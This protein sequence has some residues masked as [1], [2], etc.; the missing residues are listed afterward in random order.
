MAVVADA[1]RSTL[2]LDGA[3]CPCCRKPLAGTPVAICR[4]CIA[5]YHGACASYL[6]ACATYGCS[7]T[8][9]TYLGV[10]DG[11]VSVPKGDMEWE[12]P[13]ADPEP[14]PLEPRGVRSFSVRGENRTATH[15]SSSGIPSWI[16][17]AVFLVAINL[18]RFG[19][20]TNQAAPP[21]PTF[22][23]PVVFPG[24]SPAPL[25]IPPDA[26]PCDAC[27]GAGTGTIRERVDLP[28]SETLRNLYLLVDPW[29][30]CNG[31]G[32]LKPDRTPLVECVFCHGSNSIRGAPCRACE[33][34]LERDQRRRRGG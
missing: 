6:G 4:H 3:H 5:P 15:S 30:T 11:K 19:A 26:I 18:I 7:G 22:T 13:Q 28:T 21:P 17:V 29:G 2:D 16:W 34:R 27:E 31:S 25:R 1:D 9:F 14:I 32:R 33:R 12:R 23:A 20:K 8:K 10:V 24:P